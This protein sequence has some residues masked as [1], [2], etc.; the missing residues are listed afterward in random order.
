MSVLVEL[1]AGGLSG[2]GPAL[3]PNYQ[4]TQGVVMVA[5]KISAFQPVA[6]FEEVAGSFEQALKETPR[7]S[8]EDE[9]LLPGEP[10]WRSKAERERDGIPLPEKTWERLRETAEAMGVAWGDASE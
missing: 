9:I 6:T 10:E 3:L 8:E 7:A 1:V 4:R 2:A 5:L